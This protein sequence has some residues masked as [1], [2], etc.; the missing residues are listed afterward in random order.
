MVAD[1]QILESVPDESTS[2][3]TIEPAI[4]D[5]LEKQQNDR[6]YDFNQ[7]QITSKLETAFMAW[8]KVHR[9]NLQSEPSNYQQLNGHTFKNQLRE[10]ITSHMQE[11]SKQFN[12]WKEVSHKKA[13]G[14][15]VLRCQWVFKYKT[16]KHDNLQK[17]KARLIVC[18]NQQRNHNFSTRAIT[19]AI[20]FLRTLLAIAA[21]FDLKTL[22]LNVVNAFVH[23]NLDET[24]FMKI[25]PG[26]VQSGKVLKLNK[27]LYDLYWSLFL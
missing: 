8:I 24:V 21:K 10:N 5:H 4:L 14:Y 23:A 12:S 3:Y 27:V 7:H 13:A 18:G 15:Q 9:R 19:W 22:Q 20:I 1:N 25:P 16:D 2:S 11:H 6:F 26:Y 17:S